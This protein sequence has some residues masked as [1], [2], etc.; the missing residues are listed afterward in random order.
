MSEE[1]KNEIDTNGEN[2]DLTDSNNDQEKNNLKVKG[3]FNKI[4]KEFFSAAVKNFFL[5]FSYDK[6]NFLHR[7]NPQVNI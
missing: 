4:I 1:F 2:Q 6:G 7:I 3:S 5:K